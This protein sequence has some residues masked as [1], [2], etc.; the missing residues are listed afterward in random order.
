ML[1]ENFKSRA[2]IYSKLYYILFGEA[3]LTHIFR[4]RRKMLHA[5]K[6]IVA[7]SVRLGYDAV[8][9]IG[10]YVCVA[11]ERITKVYLTYHFVPYGVIIPDDR[12]FV[13]HNAL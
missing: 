2:D 4:Q 6:N 5:Y 3:V 10:H 8:I 7:C 13:R 1:V 9:L 11:P 12:T